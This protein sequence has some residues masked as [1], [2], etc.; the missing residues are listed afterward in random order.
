[1]LVTVVFFGS[2]EFSLSALKACI[3]AP[4]KILRVITTPDRKKGR[5]L[6]EAAT[7]VRRFAEESGLAVSAPETLKTGDLIEEVRALNPELFVVS[8]YG[9]IIP[10]AWLK[11]PSRY[12]LN[13]HPSLLP[14]YRGAAPLNWP[15]LNGDSETALSIAEVTD[16][17][18]AG[19]IFYQKKLPILDSDDSQILSQKLAAL[20]YHAL[21][22]IFAKLQKGDSL[23][24]TAQ[25]ETASTYAR[26]LEKED[27]LVDWNQ[28]AK[29]I[30]NRVRGLLPWPAAYFNFQTEPVQILKAYLEPETDH[31]APGTILRISKEGPAAIQTAQGILILERLKPAGKK[32]MSAAEFLRGRRLAEGN[33]L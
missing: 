14:K 26:K 1:M 16:K 5:G 12:A 3:D 19:D 25:D 17:L 15:V 6:K 28:S 13:V 21:K 23:A 22:E 4:F 32:E 24:R 29:E 10:S 27:G 11:I 31:K 18:D 30:W 9:K 8:S 7:P 2:S 20:S 33:S